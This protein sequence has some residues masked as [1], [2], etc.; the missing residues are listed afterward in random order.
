MKCQS[1]IIVEL[2]NFFQVFIVYY[3]HG[4]NVSGMLIKEKK[5][6]QMFILK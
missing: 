2:L 1:T 3:I 6:V 5:C 4:I